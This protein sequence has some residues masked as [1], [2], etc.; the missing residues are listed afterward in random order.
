MRWIV[1]ATRR[2]RAR[3]RSRD[4]VDLIHEPPGPWLPGTRRR[5]GEPRVSQEGLAGEA[6]ERNIRL[7]GGGR[8][9]WAET[10]ARW[11]FEN[12][13]CGMRHGAGAET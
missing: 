1:L 7:V 2:P 11:R 6:E 10:N 13:Q 8:G 12:R 4:G 9:D 5:A 3:G